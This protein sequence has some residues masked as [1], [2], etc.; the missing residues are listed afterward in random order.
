[1]PTIIQKVRNFM[2]GV[3]ELYLVVEVTYFNVRTLYKDVLDTF[4][5]RIACQFF[6]VLFLKSRM[7]SLGTY[8]LKQR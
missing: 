7:S 6:F 1:M 4:W 3:V 2:R 5:E 8:F